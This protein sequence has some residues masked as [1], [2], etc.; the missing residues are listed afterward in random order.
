MSLH[1]FFDGVI[2]EQLVKTKQAATQN[3]NAPA[4][5]VEIIEAKDFF[6][7]LQMRGVRKSSQ[8]HLDLQRVLQL[9][10]N[11]PDLILVKRLSKAIDE[12]AKNEEIMQGIMAA[13]Q[14]GAGGET[15]EDAVRAKQ[16]DEAEAVKE[17]EEEEEMDEYI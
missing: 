3:K 8:P 11:Y 10:P 2:Y 17:A 13:A 16:K 6:E 7:Y 1:E 14:E 9:D 12:V 4:R 15:T 5:K